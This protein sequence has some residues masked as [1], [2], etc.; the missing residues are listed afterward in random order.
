MAECSFADVHTENV[1]YCPNEEQVGG[2]K[3]KAWY[4]PMAQLE[5]ITKPT[6]TSDTTFEES[7]ILSAL[8]PATGKGFKRYDLIVDENE[9]K[10]AL[11]GSKGNLKDQGQLDA[12]LPGLKKKNLGFIKRMKNVPTCWIV[13]DSTGQKW[14]ILDGYMTKADTTSAKKYDENSGT[15]I[16]IL[17][18]GPLWAFDGS[19]VE[20]ADVVT[21]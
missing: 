6:V 20:L 10:S 3:A 15:A 18:N 1:A 9:L 8:T 2:I 21:P 16:N 13:E 4:I 11:V 19:I 14:V 7:I 12:M 17:G 5:T